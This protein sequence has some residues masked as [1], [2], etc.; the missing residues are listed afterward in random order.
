MYP[1][2]CTSSAFHFTLIVLATLN[3]VSIIIVSFIHYEGQIGIIY[4]MLNLGVA[5][6]ALDRSVAVDVDKREVKFDYSFIEGSK[7]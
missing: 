1:M 3:F 7:E 2:L 5:K 4:Q 6:E